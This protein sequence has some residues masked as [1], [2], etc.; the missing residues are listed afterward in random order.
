MLSARSRLL[1]ET[2]DF[3]LWLHRRGGYA[4]EPSVK[5]NALSEAIQHGLIELVRSGPDAPLVVLT[6]AGVSEAERLSG[7]SLDRPNLLRDVRD[8]RL[9]ARNPHFLWLAA[10]YIY[11]GFA[12]FYVVVRLIFFWH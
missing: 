5:S 4:H 2:V 10:A 3:I 8:V 6:P 12:C 11:L 1:P 7:M 9:A